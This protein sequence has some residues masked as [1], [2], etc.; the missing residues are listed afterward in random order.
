MNVR[1]ITSQYG[2][3]FRNNNGE[4]LHEA[5]LIDVLGSPM[6]LEGYHDDKNI[7]SEIKL[8]APREQIYSI[9][10]TLL[11]GV[12]IENPFGDNIVLPPSEMRREEFKT[13]P[14]RVYSGDQLSFVEYLHMVLNEGRLPTEAEAEIR[15]F[16]S[17]TAAIY[18]GNL[19]DMVH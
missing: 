3:S 13:G 4:I 17:T 2:T 14:G 15:G 18:A 16:N 7:W 6:V 1:E 5:F 9:R 19:D 10:K 8:K 11:D 12:N